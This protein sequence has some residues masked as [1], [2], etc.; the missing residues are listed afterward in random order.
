MG[1]YTNSINESKPAKTWLYV[2]GNSSAPRYVATPIGLDVS[3]RAYSTVF[4]LLPLQSMMPMLGFSL[5][6][7]TISSNAER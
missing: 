7:R 6:S 4:S 2:S 5:G 1:G 3:R